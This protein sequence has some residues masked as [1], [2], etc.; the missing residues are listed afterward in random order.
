MI[1]QQFAYSKRA[2]PPHEDREAR[3]AAA[4]M[5]GGMTGHRGLAS[6]NVRNSRWF[7]GNVSGGA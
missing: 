3:R 5:P 4:E 1:E 6:A 7:P 2:D